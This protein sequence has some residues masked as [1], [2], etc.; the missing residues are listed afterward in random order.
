MSNSSRKFERHEAGRLVPHLRCVVH[1]LH[2]TKLT[3][4]MPE[5]VLVYAVAASAPFLV[6]EM[7]RLTVRR[8]T[9]PAA[10]CSLACPGPGCACPGPPR[11][12]AGPPHQQAGPGAAIRRIGLWVGFVDSYGVDLGEQV[13]LAKR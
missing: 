13:R 10:W 8:I 4:A 1:G 12:R 11:P 7:L 2:V 3:L 6:L 5:W 9:L